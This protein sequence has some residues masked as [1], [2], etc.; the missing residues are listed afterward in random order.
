MYTTRMMFAASV[1]A[2]AAAS[3]QAA[4]HDQTGPGAAP[5][6]NA[7]MQGMMAQAGTGTGPGTGNMPP[8]QAMMNAGSMGQGGMGPG[9]GG[10]CGGMMGGGMVGGGRGHPMMLKM[11]LAMMDTDGNGSLSLDEVQAVHARIFGMAD[12]NADGQ[13]RPDEIRDFMMGGGA[14]GPNGQQGQSSQ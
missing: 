2:L 10:Q 5:Q 1:L 4:Q 7:P 9:S 11:M 13:L 8:G 12:T 14:V 3:A 6:A